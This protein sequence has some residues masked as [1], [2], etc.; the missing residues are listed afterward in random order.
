MYIL[1]Y[2]LYYTYIYNSTYIIYVYKSFKSY[3]IL[4]KFSARKQFSEKYLLILLYFDLFLENKME[5]LENF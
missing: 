3:K 1:Y 2:K 5:I 4:G